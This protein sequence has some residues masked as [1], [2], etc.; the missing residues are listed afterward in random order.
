MA[1]PNRVLL[2]DDEADLVTSL[3]YA[4]E[5]EGY[6][7]VSAST[8][9]RALEIA[10]QSPTPDLVLLDLMLP[11]ISGNEV[12]QRLRSMENTRSVPI[13]M[14]TARG[15]EVDRVVGFE[16]GADDFVPKPFSLR[17]LMLRLRAVLRRSRTPSASSTIPQSKLVIGD[18]QVDPSSH[19]VW[20]QDKEVTLTA[21]EFRLLTT[22]IERR[23]RVQSRSQLLSDI[24]GIRGDVETRTVD[25]HIKRL[26]H[27]LE[28]AGHYIETLRGVG[29][30][31]TD[32]R[33][34][35]LAG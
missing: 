33:E 23:G 34:E 18:L 35:S 7:V 24:W 8:G 4:L 19:R 28:E 5:R 6:S 21:L 31:F 17:E 27:K 29:Y 15:E 11:D 10:A 12:C 14:L 20:V 30:R 25:T 16:L 26:R 3:S 22:L 32:V 2:V 9:S 13:V 1:T